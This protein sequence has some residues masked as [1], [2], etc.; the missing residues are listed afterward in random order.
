M[1]LPIVVHSALAERRLDGFSF[2]SIRTRSCCG[3]V[4]NY[5]ALISEQDKQCLPCCANFSMLLQ[6][7]ISTE[8]SDFFQ[9]NNS[10]W[11]IRV[12]NDLS[13]DTT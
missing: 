10:S 2:T 13:S 1:E 8:T 3:N 4:N 11:V 7:K 5:W 6:T 9:A 12:S